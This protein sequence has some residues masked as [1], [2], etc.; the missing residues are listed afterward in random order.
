M[1]AK[2]WARDRAEA[3][4]ALLVEDDDLDA[5]ILTAYAGMYEECAIHFTRARTV[6]EALRLTRDAQFDLYFVDFNLGERSTL[7]LLTALERD[8]RRPVV[9]SSISLQEAERYR[10]NSGALRFL[11]KG[12]VSAASLH[13]L[14][15]EALCARGHAS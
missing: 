5:N 10:L 6:G 11:P 3:L 1:N 8:G 2:G 9:I 12:D 4:E 15:S 13:P 14:A 7:R